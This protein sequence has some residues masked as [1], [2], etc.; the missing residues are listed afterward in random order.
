MASI[1]K[2]AAEA[3]RLG[4]SFLFEI[5]SGLKSRQ[6]HLHRDRSVALFNVR[7]DADLPTW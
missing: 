1:K 3:D 4:S 2:I 5:R 7:R 6:P